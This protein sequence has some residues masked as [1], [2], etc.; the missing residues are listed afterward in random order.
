MLIRIHRITLVK[1]Y[2]FVTSARVTLSTQFELYEMRGILSHFLHN[3]DSE[4]EITMPMINGLIRTSVTMIKMKHFER[5]RDNPSMGDL[6]ALA[7][8]LVQRHPWFKNAGVL[9]SL[10]G[11]PLEVVK[12]KVKNLNLSGDH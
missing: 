1:F 2:K 12:R 5:Y 10:G 7:T 3:C 9:K 4:P 8:I 6:D 11:D